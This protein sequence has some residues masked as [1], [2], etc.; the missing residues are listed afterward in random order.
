[1]TVQNGVST[2]HDQTTSD[3]RTLPN[4]ESVRQN[5]NG[6]VCSKVKVQGK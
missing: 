4:K 6:Q 1:M 5:L 2:A 3:K